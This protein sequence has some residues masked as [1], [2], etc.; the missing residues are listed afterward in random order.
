MVG[1]GVCECVV[2]VVVPVRC[3]GGVGVTCEDGGGEDVG[4]G[5]GG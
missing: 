4:C 2:V 3:G 1:G 5:D